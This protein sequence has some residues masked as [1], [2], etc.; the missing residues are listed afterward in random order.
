MKTL[1]K[2]SE[3]L[4]DEFIELLWPINS[5]FN[6]SIILIEKEIPSLLN[7]DDVID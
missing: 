4:K 1:R 3:M 6:L 5:S 7:Y 2:K